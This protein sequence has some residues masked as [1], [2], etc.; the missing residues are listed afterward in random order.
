MRTVPPC[1]TCVLGDV[2]AAVQQV[3]ADPAVQLAVARATGVVFIGFAA[4]LLY[5]HLA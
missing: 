5:D 3:T 1:L 4:L 2:Y